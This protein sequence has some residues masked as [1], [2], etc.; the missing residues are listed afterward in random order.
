MK[1]LILIIDIL[2]AAIILYLF[3]P[4]LVRAVTRFGKGRK[5]F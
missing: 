5:K 2:A 1:A 4:I 3:L